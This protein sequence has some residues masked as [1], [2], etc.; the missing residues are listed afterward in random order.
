MRPSNSSYR[1]LAGAI[2]YPVALSCCFFAADARPSLPL[3]F[4]LIIMPVGCSVGAVVAKLEG[5]RM[6]W[7]AIIIFI[8]WLALVAVCY[9][10]LLKAA[11]ASV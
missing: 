6:S 10:E 11:A 5:D 9:V 1:L 2:A 8:A 7:T 4:F 3:F